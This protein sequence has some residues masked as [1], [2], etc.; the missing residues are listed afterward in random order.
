MKRF[1]LL[2]TLVI[3][4]CAL[5]GVSYSNPVTKHDVS[6]CYVSK[7]VNHEANYSNLVSIIPTGVHA[8]EGTIEYI[9]LRS[10]SVQKPAVSKKLYILQCKLK[11]C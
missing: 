7:K 4:I 5:C 3:A 1:C 10:P 11:L 2:S 9:A 8:P 6:D